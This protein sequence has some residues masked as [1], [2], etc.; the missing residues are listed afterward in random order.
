MSK[1][2]RENAMAIQRE[3]K[4][5]QKGEHH[6][7]FGKIILILLTIV[8]LGPLI[9]F[10]LIFLSIKFH[11]F[12]PYSLGFNIIIGFVFVIFAIRFILKNL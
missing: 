12:S 2:E 7:G 3:T 10:G 4:M 5:L 1:K 8:V 9:F 11:Y 6:I